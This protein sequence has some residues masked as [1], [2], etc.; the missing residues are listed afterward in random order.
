MGR[1]LQTRPFVSTN[2][3]YLSDESM[4]A[5]QAWGT[6]WAPSMVA[7]TKGLEPARVLFHVPVSLSTLEVPPP[8][9]GAVLRI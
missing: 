4:N 7:R 8:S 1:C 5:G 3:T 2:L 6:Y 9:P